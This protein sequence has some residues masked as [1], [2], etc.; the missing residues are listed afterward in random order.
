[1]YV[2]LRVK[3][4]IYV[5]YILRPPYADYSLTTT[6]RGIGTVLH[7]KSMVCQIARV[8]L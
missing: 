3:L 2:V 5:Y 4:I 6:Q 7:P 1:M 8:K